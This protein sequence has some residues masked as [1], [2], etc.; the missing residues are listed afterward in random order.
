MSG[1][2]ALTAYRVGEQPDLWWVR[3]ESRGCLLI[4]LR[5]TTGSLSQQVYFLRI[6]VSN[7]LE[8]GSGATDQAEFVG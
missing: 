4:W 7:S 2:E 5:H 6:S 8:L 3:L 1:E